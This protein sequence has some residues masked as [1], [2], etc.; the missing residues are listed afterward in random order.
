EDF[1]FALLRTSSLQILKAAGFEGVESGSAN[2][3]TDVFGKYIQLLASTSSEYARLAGRSH[4]N[5]LDVVDGLNELSIDLKSL[6]DWL[7]VDG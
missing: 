7:Q 1:C 6:E 2:A 3:L 4:A 5:A